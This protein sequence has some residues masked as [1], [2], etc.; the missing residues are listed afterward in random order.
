[1]GAQYVICGG[2]RGNMPGSD[3]VRSILLEMQVAAAP[4]QTLMFPARG[5]S[6]K[7]QIPTKIS[8]SHEFIAEYPDVCVWEVYERAKELIL[9]GE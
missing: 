2:K 9:E 3:T 1:M 6:G 8:N 4:P 7:M 5:N